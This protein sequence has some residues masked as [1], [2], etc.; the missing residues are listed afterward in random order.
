MTFDRSAIDTSWKYLRNRTKEN[1]ERLVS[2]SGNRLA[3]DH[4]SWS[5][6]S[7]TLLAK[8]VPYVKRYLISLM[9]QEVPESRAR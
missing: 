1:L 6:I 8:E 9:T 2:N 4:F 3:Y 7:S 5:S